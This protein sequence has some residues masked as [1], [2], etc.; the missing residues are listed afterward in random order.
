[1]AARLAGPAGASWPVV[2]LHMAAEAAR[3]GVR[4]LAAL[5]QAE[6]A[7]AALAAGPDR[8]SHR[9][10]VLALLLRQPALTAPALARALAITPQAALRLLAPLAAAGVVA[11]VTGRKSFRAFG[12]LCG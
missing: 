10:A 8:R 3:A 1:M 7:G 11:E 12:I 4:M 5:R 2:F 9:P 6:Q